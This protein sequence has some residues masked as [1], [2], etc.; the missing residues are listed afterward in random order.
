MT[1]PAA[2]TTKDAAAAAAD[3]AE[4]CDGHAGA[5]QFFERRFTLARAPRAPRF[6]RCQAYAYVFVPEPCAMHRFG[7][8]WKIST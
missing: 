8:D 4:V 6:V 5:L 7:V 1:T 2:T 3:T